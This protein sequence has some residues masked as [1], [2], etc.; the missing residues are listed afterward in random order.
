M[1]AI[2]AGAYTLVL[3]NGQRL[4]IPS[5]FTLTKTT[6]TYEISP[7]FNKTMQLILIDVAAT[8]R[9]NKEVPGSF[10]KHT[11]QSPVVVQPAPQAIRTLTNRDLMAVR[12][13]RIESE[14]AY[15]TRRKELG[16]PTV[17]E[18]RSRQAADG[19]VL[20]EQ[21]REANIAKAR[22]E[23]FW[24]QRAR[25]LRTEI[26]TVDAQIGYVRGRLSEVNE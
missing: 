24:R 14:Q 5:E 4:E 6:L 16:L 22:E 21:I 20:R 3:R 7:G 12:Q 25:A 15:E 2:T 17:E 26:A 1:L 9:A 8:E 18:T 19:A 10:F 11:E 23:T 13:R